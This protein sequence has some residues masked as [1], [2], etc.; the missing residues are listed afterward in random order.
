MGNQIF[1]VEGGLAVSLFFVAQNRRS[2]GMTGKEK[3]IKQS[4]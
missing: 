1:L 3:Q 2:M 4:R